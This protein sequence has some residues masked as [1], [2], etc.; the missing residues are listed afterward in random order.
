[1][2]TNKQ[3]E[4]NQ[5]KSNE[6]KEILLKRV[7]DGDKTPIKKI[8]AVSGNREV[9]VVYFDFV[10]YYFE[11]EHQFKRNEAG[12]LDPIP[13]FEG[14]ADK[15]LSYKTKIGSNKKE[16]P[17]SLENAEGYRVTVFIDNVVDF[18]L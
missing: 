11:R 2:A 12:E 8:Q 1:M 3:L 15:K 5:E 9:E 10:P 17:I 7:F 16:N 14:E 6:L 4:P 18:E 13:A